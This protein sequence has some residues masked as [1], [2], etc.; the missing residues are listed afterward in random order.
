MPS[1]FLPWKM[2]NAE[3][4]QPKRLVAG[5]EENTGEKLV[6]P[7]AVAASSGGDQPEE[8]PGWGY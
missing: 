5:T 6:T 8:V 1:S 7:K 4:K 2:H 3:A